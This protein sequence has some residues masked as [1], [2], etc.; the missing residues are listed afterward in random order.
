MSNNDKKLEERLL[1]PVGQMTSEELKKIV[2]ESEIE[3]ARRNMV[4]ALKKQIA[5]KEKDFYKDEVIVFSKFANYEV[6]NAR[7]K[8]L[9]HMRG[10]EVIGF[11]STSDRQDKIDFGQKKIGTFVEISNDNFKGRVTFRHFEIN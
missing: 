6:F 4:E 1:K 2:S 9:N 5:V 3:L 11:F 7:S 10:D 8:S